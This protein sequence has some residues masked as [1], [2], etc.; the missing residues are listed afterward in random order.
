[1]VIPLPL[2]N[3]TRRRLD[4]Q[5]LDFQIGQFPVYSFEW[6]GVPLTSAKNCLKSWGLPWKIVFKI[7]GLSWKFVWIFFLEVVITVSPIWG[8]SWHV[9]CEGVM[10]FISQSLIYIYTHAHTCVHT[11]INRS[12]CVYT[13]VCIYTYKCINICIYIYI[14]TYINMLKHEYTYTYMY[15]KMH[16]HK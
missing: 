4:L 3:R 7:W 11:F 13:C 8:T 10:S 14:C 5:Y 9:R 12:I 2:T 6:Q 15:A 16:K 1:M